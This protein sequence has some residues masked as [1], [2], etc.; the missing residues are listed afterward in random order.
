LTN[1]VQ[2]KK[3]QLLHEILPNAKE[4]AFIVNPTN[5]AWALQVRELQDAAAK[6]GLLLNVLNASSQ[7]E[8]KS[9]L[10]MAGQHGA[11][12]VFLMS[13]G[14]LTSQSAMI[15][16]LA[17]QYRIPTFA[18][19]EQVAVGALLGYGPDI[20]DAYRQSGVYVA[21][22]LKGAKPADLPVVQT[23]KLDLTINLQTA[24]ALGIEVPPGLLAIADKVIE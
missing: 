23:N 13:D 19:P 12:A 10:T 17:L 15:V 3:L 5:P 4:I 7:A 20:A 1:E 16:A 9:A 11:A 21:R 22:I 24:R 18:T 14:F 6:L 8:I 2:P